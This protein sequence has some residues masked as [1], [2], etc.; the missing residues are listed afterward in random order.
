MDKEFAHFQ[1]KVPTKLWS[2]FKIKTIE[3]G[4]PTYKEKLIE[5]ITKYVNR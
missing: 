4:S 5:L 1:F 3:D 2:K